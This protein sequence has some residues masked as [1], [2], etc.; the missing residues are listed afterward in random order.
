MPKISA[1]IHAHND[2]HRLGR[3]LET[4]RPCDEIIVIDHSSDGETAKLAREYGA[5]V[6]KAILGVEGGAYAMNTRHEWVL[7]M[8][9]DEIISEGL[10]A[11]LLQWKR[12][13]PGTVFGYAL[14]VREQKAD[15]W[16]HLPAETRL[17]NRA[18]V[19]WKDELPPTTGTTP[20]LQGDLLRFPDN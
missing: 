13:K 8:R 18:K 14:S 19:N 11:T 6:R 5:S 16:R 7:C 3:T 12:S 17:V 1:I 4:L 15:G 10:E 20:K 9:P 2:A